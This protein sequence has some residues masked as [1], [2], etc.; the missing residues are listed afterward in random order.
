MAQVEEAPGANASPAWTAPCLC[1]GRSARSLSHCGEEAR[2]YPRE[3]GLRRSIGIPE[4]LDHHQAVLSAW[5]RLLLA[6]FYG[7]QSRFF[8]G[9][10]R[11]FE[12]EGGP[13]KWV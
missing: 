11:C 7:Q 13:F 2:Y 3:K 4:K 9:T 5:H 6:K 12:G 8:V 1:R 10:W